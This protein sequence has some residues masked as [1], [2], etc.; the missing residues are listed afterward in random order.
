[1]ALAAER[2]T[3]APSG[4][5]LYGSGTAALA[6]VLKAL[7]DRRNRSE[8]EVVV[9]AYG[10]PALIAAI[11]YADLVPVL[12]DLGS[13]SPFVSG[14]E[15]RRRMSARTVAAV[16]V[17]FLGLEPGRPPV[18]PE[19]ALRNE[20]KFVY[21]CCQGWPAGMKCPDWAMATVVSFGR[22]KPISLGSG[23]GVLVSPQ[24]EGQLTLP[25]GESARRVR[26]FRLRAS[27]YNSLLHPRLYWWMDKVPFLGLGK[28]EY[29]PLR[30]IS[31]MPTELA[32]HLPI[33][34]TAYSGDPGWTVSRVESII[35]LGSIGAFRVLPA[36]R[37]SPRDTRL[38]RLPLLAGTASA[39]DEAV[40][41]LRRRGYGATAMYR[42]PLWKIRGLE[43]LERY[44]STCPNAVRFADQLLTLP[45]HRR[46]S[47][48]HL[49]GMAECLAKL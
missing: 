39:R 37:D 25:A 11:L 19:C 31:A 10:C 47:N 29:R 32:R 46:V 28:T 35:G 17:N 5:R 44:E 7:V 23:G 26:S 48:G 22:G 12:A 6:A 43:F 49:L 33:N 18:S 27:L 9:P 36:M 2:S 42:H 13:S 30:Q 16:P 3:F 20:P 34:I 1:M 38:L 15:W 24:V 45:V 21:D 4:L 41:A 14:D 8:L 40:A